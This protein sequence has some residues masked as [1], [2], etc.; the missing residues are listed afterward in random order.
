MDA[1]TFPGVCY[2][3]FF[4]ALISE[5]E[6]AKCGVGCISVGEFDKEQ[7]Y[8]LPAKIR[9][10]VARL[11]WCR[12]QNDLAAVTQC[13]HYDQAQI[14]Q[15]H[16]KSKAIQA[17]IAQEYG[18]GPF[19]ILEQAFDGARLRLWADVLV[20]I[21]DLLNGLRHLFDECE[22]HRQSVK[23]HIADMRKALDEG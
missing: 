17:A 2:P 14:A 22:Q 15:L 9:A 23:A 12:K 5:L 20:L 7:W 3:D 19:C 16:I 11:A 1:Q 8:Q 21:D 6:A 4:T 18:K 13:F 10:V